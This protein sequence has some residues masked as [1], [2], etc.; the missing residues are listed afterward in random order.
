MT[1]SQG[2]RANHPIL[3]SVQQALHIPPATNRLVFNLGNRQRHCSAAHSWSVCP[4]GPD[5]SRS[6]LNTVLFSVVMCAR[7]TLNP[8]AHLGG[9]TQARSKH[10][11]QHLLVACGIFPVGTK[12][13]PGSTV[14][15]IGSGFLEQPK[16]RPSLDSRDFRRTEKRR[17][18]RLSP[19]RVPCNVV[20]PAPT[21]HTPSLPQLVLAEQR[22][23]HIAQHIQ[24]LCSG[25]EFGVFA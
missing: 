19:G 18:A 16:T 6:F 10:F 12:T 21:P 20:A 5:I 15:K 9:T 2:L 23:I 8:D 24:E 22:N 25:A 17:S 1:I 11:S 4:P 7:Q 3:I 14:L 13:S